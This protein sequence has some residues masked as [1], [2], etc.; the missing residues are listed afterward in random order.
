MYKEKIKMKL[1]QDKG[2]KTLVKDPD[3]KRPYIEDKPSSDED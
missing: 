1:N 3:Y 2:P